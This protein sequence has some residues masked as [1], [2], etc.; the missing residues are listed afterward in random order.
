MIHLPSIQIWQNNPK[1]TKPCSFSHISTSLLFI[2]L[3]FLLSFFF[4]FFPSYLFTPFAAE[5]PLGTTYPGSSPFSFSPPSFLPSPN[6]PCSSSPTTQFF[7]AV[8]IKRRSTRNDEFARLNKSLG[9]STQPFVF[10][11]LIPSRVSPVS[12][13][14]SKIVSIH[15]VQVN[16]LM[17]F[18]TPFL[19]DGA[20]GSIRGSSRA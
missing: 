20:K 18:Q 7:I 2:K 4:L 9:R 17:R 16:D 11:T 13:F 3:S 8:K 10:L 15:T 5:F 12:G 19:L 14:L 1:G 6:R